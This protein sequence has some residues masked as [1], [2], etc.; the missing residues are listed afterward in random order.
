MM[1]KACAAEGQDH[2]GGSV[3]LRDG[4]AAG[5]ARTSGGSKSALRLW[6]KCR[7]MAQHGFEPSEAVE[8][9]AGQ[10][11]M[12]DRIRKLEQESGVL[13]EAAAYLSPANLAIGHP[14]QDDVP[15][16]PVTLPPPASRGGSPAECWASPLRSSPHAQRRPGRRTRPGAGV[17]ARCRRSSPRRR[18]GNRPPDSSSTNSTP[19]AT[20]SQTAESGG[21]AR[22]R[23]CRRRR[24]TPGAAR[25]TRQVLRSPMIRP[26]ASPAF[27][28]PYR[29]CAPQR[30]PNLQ[31]T[32]STGP[33]TMRRHVG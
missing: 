2:R 13:R 22:C 33:P 24:S 28:A 31:Q 27:Q 6:V 3:R 18:P 5:S 12:L 21:C 26:I 16:A 20:R 7:R 19:P 11:S 14:A 8:D 23:G 32:L 1:P 10:T 25:R 29:R 17:S 4:P 30:Q 15:A 9:R